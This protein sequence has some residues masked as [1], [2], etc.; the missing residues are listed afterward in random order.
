MKVGLIA[1]LAIGMDGSGSHAWS[2]Q[3]EVLGGLSIGAPPDYYAADGQNWGLTTF[4]P[5]GLAASG[6]APFI[7]TLRASLRYVGGIR[8]DHVM[9]MSRLWL[10]PQGASAL[11]GAYVTFPPRPCSGS[12]RSNPGGT[13]PS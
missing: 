1:D 4:S 6:F 13:R 9:G 8:I 3:D 7:E 10:V 5:R 2:R 11:D 12:S